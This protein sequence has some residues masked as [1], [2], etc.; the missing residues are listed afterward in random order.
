MRVGAR[1]SVY[2]QGDGGSSA[3]LVHRN[4]HYDDGAVVLD[5][6]GSP[7][8]LVFHFDGQSF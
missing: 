3:H 8:F 7:R 4:G 6:A 5:P 1:A 2:A